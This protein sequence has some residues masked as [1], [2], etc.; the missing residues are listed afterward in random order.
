[1][2]AL[3]SAQ[4]KQLDILQE[5]QIRVRTSRKIQ[6]HTGLDLIFMNFMNPVWNRDD[7]KLLS[8]VQFEFLCS[9]MNITYNAQGSSWA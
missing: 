4:F 7:T 2:Q 8:L 9:I 5:E 1:M 6:K 3:S